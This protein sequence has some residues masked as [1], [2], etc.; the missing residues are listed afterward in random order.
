[1]RLSLD[2]SLLG[3]MIEKKAFEALRPTRRGESASL[4]L[5]ALIHWLRDELV[6]VREAEGETAC[7]FFCCI[8]MEPS[9]SVPPRTCGICLASGIIASS[10]YCLWLFY[11]AP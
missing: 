11:L 8:H 10:S 4:T 6:R 3:R 2:W 9:M 5:V 7:S 1:M